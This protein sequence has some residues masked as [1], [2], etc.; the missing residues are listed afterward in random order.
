MF[1]MRAE[2]PMDFDGLTQKSIFFLLKQK[3][4]SWMKPKGKEEKRKRIKP[5]NIVLPFFLMEVDPEVRA[6]RA[7]HDRYKIPMKSKNLVVENHLVKIHRD[8]IDSSFCLD[9]NGGNSIGE[10]PPAFH[11]L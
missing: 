4:P 7:K 5:K 6:I 11:H 9:L 8:L 1:Y 10:N 2:M 3:T